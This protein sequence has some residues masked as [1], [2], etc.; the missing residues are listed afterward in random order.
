MWGVL[1]FL[2][3]ANFGKKKKKSLLQCLWKS[4]IFHLMFAF[5]TIMDLV[6]LENKI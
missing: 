2:S 4:W 3:L 5:I 6:A 1:D